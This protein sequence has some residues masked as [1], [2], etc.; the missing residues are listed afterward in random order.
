MDEPRK[1][2]NEE[3]YVDPILPF[4]QVGF[5]LQPNNKYSKYGN[6]PDKVQFSYLK[7]PTINIR[8]EYAKLTHKTSFDVMMREYLP[9]W[10]RLSGLLEKKSIEA[11]IIALQL[12][13]KSMMYHGKKLQNR[14][15]EILK[16]NE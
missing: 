6:Y 3:K 9:V 16:G 14:I 4:M 2:M 13:L 11:E 1:E 15:E 7:H 8:E 12:E 10:R 5:V